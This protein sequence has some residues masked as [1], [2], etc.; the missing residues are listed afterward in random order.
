[1]TVLPKAKGA[2]P[3]PP[4]DQSPHSQVT[5]R[6]PALIRLKLFQHPPRLRPE[7]LSLVSQVRDGV[8][9][10]LDGYLLV[11][12][13]DRLFSAVADY[14]AGPKCVREGKAMGLQ[15][16]CAAASNGRA[17]KCLDAAVKAGSAGV[18]DKNGDVREAGVQLM[19]TLLQ[20]RQISWQN[21]QSIILNV[22]PTCNP[23]SDVVAS[24]NVHHACSGTVICDK[25]D[26]ICV[27]SHGQAELA[28]ACSHL[29]S[30]SRSS[31]LEA[32]EKVAASKEGAALAA[33]APAPVRHPPA[34]GKCH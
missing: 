31:A 29:D 30:S 32:I 3:L 13:P 18:H 28:Q 33:K 20:V 6:D 7:L 11:A 34:Q 9:T 24:V 22:Y 27:Q 21:E 17:S 19:L 16:F 14:L 12:S 8:I 26:P 4:T 15:W 23:F 2:W 1:M 25:H 5:F 10:M